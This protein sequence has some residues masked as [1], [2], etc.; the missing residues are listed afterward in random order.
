MKRHFI[1]LV[2]ISAA[3][4]GIVAGQ[5]APPTEPPVIP[6]TPTALN[7]ST[8]TVP[9]KVIWTAPAKPKRM[10]I[11]ITVYDDLNSNALHEASFS[12]EYRDNCFVKTEIVEE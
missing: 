11:R 5:T 2:L 3:L 8:N 12:T 10:I 4:G 1:A 6:P 7:T 9:V